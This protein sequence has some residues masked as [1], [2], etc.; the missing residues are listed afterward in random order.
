MASS[1]TSRVSC[2]L[3]NPVSSSAAATALD[4][5]PRR[6]PSTVQLTPSWMLGDHRWA[7]SHASISTH[8]VS[9]TMSP[10]ASASGIS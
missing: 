4:T 10:L 9:G 1:V 2:P 8:R 5:S 3:R 7:C 6:R